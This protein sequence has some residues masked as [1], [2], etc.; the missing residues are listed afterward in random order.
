MT[1]SY[2]N[3]SGADMRLSDNDG[4]YSFEPRSNE[5]W[6]NRASDNGGGRPV[7]AQAQQP[8]SQ[9]GTED[10]NATHRE[11]ASKKYKG[12]SRSGSEW[13]AG[14]GH[15]TS[16]RRN[17]RVH[18]GTFPTP[19]MAAIAFDASTL[20]LKGDSWIHRL[21]FPRYASQI[22]NILKGSSSLVTDTNIR[23]VA[24]K[25]AHQ[26]GLLISPEKDEGLEFSPF[27]SLEQR[28]QGLDVSPLIDPF[29]AILADTSGVTSAPLISSNTGMFDSTSNVYFPV[30]PSQ[31]NQRIQADSCAA[32]N[33]R[34]VIS[35]ANQLPTQI[36]AANQVY[37]MMQ[38]RTY[39]S[40][41]ADIGIASSSAVHYCTKPQDVAIPTSSPSSMPVEMESSGG[42]VNIQDGTL[43]M[44][45]PLRY[46]PDCVLLHS[47]SNISDADMPLSDNY[48]GYSFEPRSN[49]EGKNYTSHNGGGRSISAQ[50]QQP[51]SQTGAG[52]RNATHREEA[53]K[54]YKGVSPS[55]SK[56]VAGVRNSTSERKNNRVHLGTFPTPEMAA[57]AF[58][59]SRLFLKGDSSI[60]HLNFPWYA[61]QIKNILKRSSSLVTTTNIKYVAWKAAR[62]LGPL[63]SPEK[64]NRGLEASVSP[65]INLQ[66]R[67]HQGQEFSTGIPA[68]TPAHMIS[69]MSDS[70]SNVD[71]PLSG[72]NNNFAAWKTAKDLAPV[73]SPEKEEGLEFSP[74]MSLEQKDQGLD[75]SQLINP[76]GDTSGVTSA[77]LI[78]SNTGTFD[79]TSNVYFPVLPS[80]V[81]F[82]SNLNHVEF[83][84]ISIRDGLFHFFN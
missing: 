75:V 77:P 79:S 62:Q 78:S 3:I 27:M 46:T 42:V 41:A 32:G 36:P 34:T 11:E 40:A 63:I 6:E 66:Q 68:A 51:T 69:G 21:N 57:I 24:W 30:L 15:S 18:L 82:I 17:N 73:M 54:K 64:Q 7:S 71:Y 70:N 39:M 33:I 81:M 60:H 19:E 55:G 83:L 48:G 12:V 43:L 53:S 72:G 22:K 37:S 25:A 49:E 67:D 59:A 38:S 8:A 56:W 2:S 5:E 31:V 52:D 14:V 1:H 80:Q 65:L 45:Y 76:F 10:R 84:Y 4:G 44:Q 50:A 13:V 29:A 20:F 47:D 16:E 28:D 9:T 26:L 58:D 61:S 23:S 74:L 35:S